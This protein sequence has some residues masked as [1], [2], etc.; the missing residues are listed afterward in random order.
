MLS[1]PLGSKRAVRLEGDWLLNPREID[2]F[3]LLG[4]SHLEREAL[5]T[6]VFLFRLTSANE[7]SL[8]P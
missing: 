6:M 1:V 5:T 7:P 2:G 3:D 8:D 4:S